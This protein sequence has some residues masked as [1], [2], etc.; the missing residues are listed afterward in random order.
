MPSKKIISLSLIQISSALILSACGGGGSSNAAPT[1]KG[2]SFQIPENAKIG[3]VVGKVIGK[4]EDGDKLTYSISGNKGVFAINKDTGNITVAKSPTFNPAK[5]LKITIKVADTEN[6]DASAV[7]NIKITDVN[8]IPPSL[9]N[10][11]SFSIANI[12]TNSAVVGVLGSATDGLIYSIVG[13]NTGKA[14]AIDP[15]TGTITVANTTALASGGPFKLQIKVADGSV[16][17]VVMLNISVK[18]KTIIP[19]GFNTSV[20]ITGAKIKN[21]AK[22][23]APLGSTND[24][25]TYSTVGGKGAFAIDPATGQITI[26]N[27][28]LIKLKS[29]TPL[30]IRL[31]S[32][33]GSLSE[34]ATIQI[35][36][37]NLIP[38]GFNTSVAI[39]GVNIKNNA[40]IG[41]PLGSAGDGLTYSIVG[42]NGAFAIDPATGQI[43]IKNTSLIKLG[44]TT[45]LTIRM[46]ST[47]TS[48]FEE[49]TIQIA[50]GNLISGDAN[51]NNLTPLTVGENTITGSLVGSAL[52]SADN[53]LTY[54]ITGGNESG[55]F[56]IDPL[57][58]QIKVNDSGALGSGGIF[59]LEITATN[60]AGI[61]ETVTIKITTNKPPQ[62]SID[63]N[64]FEVLKRTAA[65]TVI[66]TIL[67]DKLGDATSIT[68][69]ALNVG[70]TTGASPE[71]SI[72]K[73]NEIVFK[74]GV[75]LV[76]PYSLDAVYNSDVGNSNVLKLTIS[77]VNDFKGKTIKIIPFGNSLTQGEGYSTGSIQDKRE[78][79]ILATSADVPSGASGDSYRRVMHNYQGHNQIKFDFIGHQQSDW[80]T[81][82]EHEGWSG[83]NSSN[84]ISG[85]G[86]L[87]PL[88]GLLSSP[89]NFVQDADVVMITLGVN[90]ALTQAVR[91][92][93]LGNGTS[94]KNN[95]ITIISELRK[96]NPNLI[97]LLANI[98][99]I[100][101]TN[102]TIYKFG[103]YDLKAY[104]DFDIYTDADANKLIK[105]PSSFINPLAKE[106]KD[107]LKADLAEAN[108]LLSGINIGI[109]KAAKQLSNQNSPVIIVDMEEAFAPNGVL[110]KELT[111]D[112]IH[113]NN[114]GEE[115]MAKEWIA[116]LDQYFDGSEETIIPT[117]CK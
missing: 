1:I 48:L 29:T 52:G 39:T 92:G 38:N 99:P 5:P 2:A 117:E 64:N 80:A 6:Q 75:T 7:V 106:V 114:A 94:T 86:T 72:N 25:L 78:A 18:A 66:G 110:K 115:V 36:I 4:D 35:K 100:D 73:N 28:S 111:S 55:A 91:G 27:T 23:G 47:G 22:I 88:T 50:V 62:I 44:S 45:P 82:T 15:K 81:D 16:S 33:D 8:V 93:D 112:G 60:A 74:E 30:I 85:E 96:V 108:S 46:T 3:H 9:R 59:E 11:P 19:N 71:F 113:P 63:N 98:P 76:G 24:K 43:T 103:K 109:C 97:F 57:T 89:N 68:E 67:I 10:N 40:K 77:I 83:F 34:N 56:S 14:F 53:G 12:A 31:T 105:D 54:S 116:V 95:L 69:K 58:G 49:V 102:T 42:G 41:A 79:P 17:D 26:K 87:Q 101:A 37:G 13:G 32:S 104:L 20:T 51:G 21:N 70:T 65:G 90:D 61:S 84:I 107:S